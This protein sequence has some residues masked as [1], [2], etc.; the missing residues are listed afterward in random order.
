MTSDRDPLAHRPKTARPRDG[1]RQPRLALGAQEFVKSG[2]SRFDPQDPYYFA[3]SLSWGRFFLL[4]LAAELA[5]NTLFACLYTLQPTAIANQQTPGFVSAFFFSLETLATVGYGEMY[6]ATP[7]GHVVSS[8]EILLGVIFMAIMT[9]LLFV[10]FSKPKAKILYASHPVIT[11]HNGHPTLMLRIGN[12]RM[13][14]LHDVEVRLYGLT[15][16]VSAEGQRQVNIVELPLVRSRFPVFA[17]LW[18]AMHVLDEESPLHDFDPNSE[19]VAKARLFFTITARDP[20]I[21]QNVSDLHTFTGADIRFGM[22]YVDAIEALGEDK[23][24][25]NYALLSA[26]EPDTKVRM[27]GEHRGVAVD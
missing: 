23:V 11:R 4:F 9:G 12:A 3:V 15:R 1:A 21:G 20:A 16:T 25:A 5:I 2:L 19:D 26:I 7:Y 13:S 6:P 24:I 18:T 22:R 27:S 10:R 14:L 8:A 17:I